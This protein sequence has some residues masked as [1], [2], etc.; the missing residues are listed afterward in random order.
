MAAQVVN[1]YWTEIDPATV[2]S[3]WNV[4]DAHDQLDVAGSMADDG[5]PDVE[6]KDVV[7]LDKDVH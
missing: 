7:V 4:E 5:W 3:A 6:L 1:E 2:I